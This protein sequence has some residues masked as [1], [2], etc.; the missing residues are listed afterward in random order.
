LFFSKQQWAW[1]CFF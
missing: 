1:C